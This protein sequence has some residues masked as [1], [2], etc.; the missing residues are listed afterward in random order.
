MYFDSYAYFFLFF[1]KLFYDH[2]R[3][4]SLQVL[5]GFPWKMASD[6]TTAS[7]EAAEGFSFSLYKN[8]PSLPAAAASAFIF[9][10]LTAV[11]AQRMYKTKAYYFTPF[12]IGGICKYISLCYRSHNIG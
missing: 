4:L 10:A 12:F 8:T 11:H 1:R 5:S 2:Y 7:A 3:G 9:A 6:G